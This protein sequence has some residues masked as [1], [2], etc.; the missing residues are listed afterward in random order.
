MKLMASSEVGSGAHADSAAQEDVA[1]RGRELIARLTRRRAASGLSQAQVAGLMQTSQSAVAR[2]ESG[3]HDAQL[4]TLTRYAGALGLSL[5]FVEDAGTQAGAPTGKPE[6][7]V[8]AGAGTMPERPDPDHALT[9]RQREVLQV[10]ADS[11]Q[12]HGYPPSMQEI[13]QAVGVSSTASVSHQLSSLQRKGYLY[14]DPGRP[15]TVEVRQPGD[16]GGASPPGYEG[17][18]ENEEAHM[19][20]T[21]TPAQEPA[22]VPVLGRIASGWPALAE[23]YVEDTFPLPRRVVGEGRLF[24]LRVP[25][26]SM[27]G[28]AVMDGDWVVIRQ[29]SLPRDGELVAVDINGEATVRTFQEGDERGWLVP[30]HP[31]HRPIPADKAYILG[32]VVAVLRTVR[33]PPIPR[34]RNMTPEQSG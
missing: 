12:K 20:G 21:D 14:R 25:D 26:D 7:S 9:W 27:T 6:G 29:Q 3:Q 11:V 2:L 19:P 22:Y 24:M 33:Q 1:A 23:H 13:A 28:A 4:S 8:P 18:E 32:L 34:R 31:K 30:Q 5:D 10:I 15:R 17:N 16:P